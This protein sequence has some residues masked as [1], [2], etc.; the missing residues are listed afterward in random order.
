MLQQTYSRMMPRSQMMSVL[1]FAA[2]AKLIDRSEQIAGSV[3]AGVAEGSWCTAAVAGELAG[4]SV[5]R[6]ALSTQCIAVAE[7]LGQ[8]LVFA[9]EIHWAVVA[10][11]GN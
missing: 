6:F 7:E 5:A 9:A 1:S 10:G 8:S 4:S 3:A 11:L 2:S